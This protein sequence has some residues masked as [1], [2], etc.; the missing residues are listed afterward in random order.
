MINQEGRTIFARRH[1]AN[2]RKH[3]ATSVIDCPQIM[4]ESNISQYTRKRVLPWWLRA[5]RFQFKSFFFSPDMAQRRF[6]IVEGALLLTLAIL[7]SRGLGV[8]RQIIFNY[9]FGTGAAASAY[10]AAANLP[11]TLF[12][13]IAGGALTHA[14]IPVF[15][16]YEKHRG[17]YEAWRLSSLVFNVLLVALTIMILLGEFIAPAFVNKILVP[18]YSPAE[19]A[20]T[21]SLVRIMLF[22]PLILGAGTVVT[23]ILNSRR[24]FL[25]PALALAIYNFGLIGGLLVALVFRTVGIYGPTYGILVAAALQFAVQVPGLIKQGMRYSFVWNLRDPGLHEIL[26]LLIPNALAVGVASIGGL[27]DT[28]FASY[29]P[30]QASLSALTNAQMLYALPTALIGQA[31]GQALLPHLT[32]QA[33][34]Q[35]FVRMR[36]TAIQIMGAA[37]VLTIPAALLLTLFGR[38]IIRLIFQHGAFNAHSS[39]L[40][41]LALLGYA[42]GLPG[43]ASGSLIANGFIAM[44]DTRTPLFM[45]TIAL[46]TRYSVLTLLFHTLSGE[47][48]ILAIPLALAISATVEA[49]LMLLLLLWH[50]SKK[51][52][53]DRGMQRLLQRRRAQQQITTQSVVK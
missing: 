52:P 14:F 3:P 48:M 8:V 26:R 24:Q 12:D 53:Y 17:E 22:Q 45:N 25:L 33:V 46:I 29:L 21:T 50:L 9:L 23:A 40:T 38:F 35:R 7:T 28:S 6:S 43:I 34:G 30:D 10:Y 2:S 36:Q 16:S 44:K 11:N 42:V 20:L 39:A 15:F 4:R 31:V 1:I 19:Q 49:T 13:L 41:Y 37:I 27:I 18:G 51:I 32:L 47:W 5:F